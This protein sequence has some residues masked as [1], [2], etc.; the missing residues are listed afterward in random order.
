MIADDKKPSDLEAVFAHATEVRRLL[1]EIVKLAGLLKKH[2]EL[3][4][5][6]GTFP[7][8]IDELREQPT[9]QKEER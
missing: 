9:A 7:W 6:H 8:T 2:A 3:I 1:A 4:E 5:A